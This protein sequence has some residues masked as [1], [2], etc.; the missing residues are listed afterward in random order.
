MQNN[1]A[2]MQLTQCRRVC[3]MFMA[4]MCCELSGVTVSSMAILDKNNEDNFSRLTVA[5]LDT[6]VMMTSVD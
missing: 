5:M 3:A 6:M 1:V 4:G 2:E